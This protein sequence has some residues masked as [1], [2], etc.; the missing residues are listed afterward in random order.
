[1]IAEEDMLLFEG[2]G[3]DEVLVEKVGERFEVEFGSLFIVFWSKAV[4]SKNTGVSKI[5][6]SISCFWID[7]DGSR[8]RKKERR[9]R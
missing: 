3:A 1:M 8:R 2:R 6:V 9:R 4:M 5:R 7:G